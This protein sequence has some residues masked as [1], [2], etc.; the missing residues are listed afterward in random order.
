MRTTLGGSMLFG[1]AVPLGL[2][3]SAD[4]SAQEVFF[5][6]E[7][8][9]AYQRAKGAV[10]CVLPTGTAIVAEAPPHC[11]ESG[12]VLFVDYD[13]TYPDPYDIFERGQDVCAAERIPEP[14]LPWPTS[15]AT[16]PGNFEQ[17]F[18][19]GPDDCVNYTEEPKIG[20]PTRK[21]QREAISAELSRKPVIIGIMRQ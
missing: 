18:Q 10:R 14:V 3:I 1:I 7:H 6:C 2:V 9:M 15:N 13:S 19:P 17:R 5:T 16:C 21:V 8:G 11:I 20:P 4:V 12:H